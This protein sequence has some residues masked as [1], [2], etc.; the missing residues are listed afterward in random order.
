MLL[1][2][3]KEQW[4]KISLF[5]SKMALLIKLASKQTTKFLDTARIAAN[6]PKGKALGVITKNQIYKCASESVT[7]SYVVNKL[8]TGYVEISENHLMG[9]VSMLPG[10]MAL[11]READKGKIEGKKNEILVQCKNASSGISFL[12]KTEQRDFQ[13]NLDTRMKKIEGEFSKMT[14]SLPQSV[15]QEIREN[16][17]EG[18]DNAEEVLD[19]DLEDFI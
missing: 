10:L 16:V 5:F 2:S 4:A 19:D 12:I 7:I 3:L 17:E 14:A 8:A 1:G 15:K 13:R 11:D 18:V 9:P 6:T